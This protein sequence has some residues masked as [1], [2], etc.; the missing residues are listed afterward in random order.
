MVFSRFDSIAVCG[1][2][3]KKFGSASLS[4][5]VI[6]AFACLSP[7]RA[8]TIESA[9]AKAYLANP[10]LNAQRAAV[11]A[12][13]ENVPR[14]LS[15]YRPRITATG[16]IG[17]QDSTLGG[18]ASG[19]SLTHPRGGTL[20]VDQ[21]I[22]N[23]GR[24]G[25]SVAAAEAGVLSARQ[26]LRSSEQSILLE[27]A[28]AYMD[29]LRD[30]AFL[31]LRKA[32]IEVLKEQ[33]RQT[34]D[35]FS[36]GEVTRTD[37]AQVEARLAAAQA[38]SS[39]AEGTLKASVARYRQVIGT[40][41]KSLSPARPVERHHPRSLEDAV[42]ISQ[43]E[44]P[45]IVAANHNVEVAEYQVKA[46]RADLYPSIGLSGSAQKRW[47]FQAQGR[48]LDAFALV[49]R[50][51]VPIYEGG[52]TYARVRQAKETL[53]QR[54]LEADLA[55]DRVRAAVVASWSQLE[56]ARARIASAQ[57]Q[58]EASTIALNGVREEARVGQRTT[59]DVL[60]Q[61]QELLSAR[62]NLVAAQRDRVVASYNV[63]SSMGRLSAEK[64]GLKVP[65]YDA[66][67]HYRAVRNRFIGT[68]ID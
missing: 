44:H 10:D 61:D 37:V 34:Q 7:A 25:N 19:N 4:A 68:S 30:T 13:D 47:D 6:A 46:V 62:V 12:N 23:F 36:V 53:G 56:A 55:R 1:G 31:D 8:E 38:E 16:D 17:P 33:L 57:A 48:E 64:L 40:D 67:A 24:T 59:Y 65:A 20:S 39:A 35:R 45:A 50:L 11:R 51:S 3:M 54:R 41:P 18:T 2:D 32:N 43:S 60:V 63:L 9:L 66:S 21:T 26:Q 42:R 14:A 15:G 27:A 58:V 49:G 52:E 28:Q 29:V 5:L 22:Y